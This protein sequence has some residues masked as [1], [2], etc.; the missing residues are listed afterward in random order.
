MRTGVQNDIV[1]RSRGFLVL[2]DDRWIGGR[3]AALAYLVR[4]HAILGNHYGI[5]GFVSFELMA[6]CFYEGL[7]QRL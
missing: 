1:N 6:L 3:G 4:F 7:A 5:V 2:L